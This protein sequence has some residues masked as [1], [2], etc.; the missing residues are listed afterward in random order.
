MSIV[1][2]NLCHTAIPDSSARALNELSL[3]VQ[4]SFGLRL[5][6][7][8]A[9]TLWRHSHHF[10][11]NFFGQILVSGMD[12]CTDLL[13]QLISLRLWDPLPKISMLEW[14]LQCGDEL[15]FGLELLLFLTQRFQSALPMR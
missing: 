15:L 1:K 11:G 5:Q 12:T 3:S 14:L 10:R 4:E 9:C 7:I 8:Y 6:V 13:N 2:F